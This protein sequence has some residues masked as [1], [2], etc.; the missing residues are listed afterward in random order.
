MG[1]A[2][3]FP[4]QI[5]NY[6]ANYIWEG[7]NISVQQRFKESTQLQ[8]EILALLPVMTQGLTRSQLDVTHL[9]EDALGVLKTHP[10][11]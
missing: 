10:I 4:L 1:G 2:S 11:W 5:L 9:A 7:I 8:D 6:I 3:F